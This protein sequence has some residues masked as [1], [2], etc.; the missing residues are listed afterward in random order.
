MHLYKND[1]MKCHCKIKAKASVDLLDILKLLKVG[2]ID[3]NKMLFYMAGKQGFL[4][5]RG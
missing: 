1:V 5:F 4:R 2:N 3:M